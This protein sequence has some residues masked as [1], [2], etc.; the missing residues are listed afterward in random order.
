MRFLSVALILVVLIAGCGKAK[1][2]PLPFDQVPDKVLQAAQKQ[3]PDV[4]F[5]RAMH[6]AMAITN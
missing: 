2:T 4:T 6:G 1:K 3:F 5:D